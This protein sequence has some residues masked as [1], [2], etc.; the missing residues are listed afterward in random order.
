MLYIV[1]TPIGNLG[2]MSRRALDVLNA[3]DF[4]A[5]ED[6]RRT[7]LLLNAFG[8]KKP[9]IGYRK[10][11]E[12][13]VAEQIADWLAGGE[14][15]ALVSDA[16][17]PLISDPGSVLVETLIGRG[18]PYTVVSGPCAVINALV[19]SG[20][21]AERFL[22]IGFLPEKAVDRRRLMEKY[23]DVEATLVVYS[24]PHNVLDDLAFLAEALGPRRYAV[25]RE[26]TKVHEEVIRG[27]LGEPADFTVKGE[28]VI[29]IEGARDRAARLT[30]ELSVE[31]HI[32]RYL[33][34]GLD[35]KEAIKRTAADRH[36][37]KSVVYA[38]YLSFRQ[39]RKVRPK[40][41]S[42]E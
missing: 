39:E 35:E 18:L 14:D 4:V 33:D 10:H 9:L 27:V 3:V 5:A 2:E 34:A 12:R 40:K 16:G 28:M 7:G 6:T 8:I 19:L 37:A 38:A 13:A 11:N 1:A 23:A 30:D 32:R 41:G 15:G 26:M 21:S 42:K 31:E 29:V 36:V 24:P 17:M 22:M 25:V 20:L